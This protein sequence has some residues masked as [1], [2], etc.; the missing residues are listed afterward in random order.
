MASAK[1]LTLRCTG[2]SLLADGRQQV[3]M[4]KPAETETSK[5]PSGAMV[6]NQP[7]AVLTLAVA[8]ADSANYGVGKDYT[9][10]ITG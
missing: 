1:K 2:I 10:A 8:A 4:Q 5:T 3:T 7:E 6:V 9:I